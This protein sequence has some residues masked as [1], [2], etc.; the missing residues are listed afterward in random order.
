MWQSGLNTDLYELTMMQ[1]YLLH[2]VNPQVAF[3][4][5]FRRQPYDGGFSVFAGLDDLLDVLDGIRFSPEDIAFL[6]S[7]GIFKKPFLDYLRDFRF[8]GDVYAVDEGTLVFPNEPLVRVHGS[9]IECQLIESLLL[10]VV[11]F[12]TLVATKAARIYA[13]A[14]GRGVLEFG[15]RRA[16]GFD[17]AKSATRAAYIGGCSA[18]SNTLAGK[19]YDIP[20]KGTMAHSWVMAFEDE[21]EAFEKFADMYPDSAVLLIDTYDTLGSGI[22]NAIPVGRRLK[23]EGKGFGV[24]LDSGDLHYLSQEIRRR[25]DE[26]GLTDATIVASNELNEEIIHQLVTDGAP[27]DLWGVGTHLV[28]GGNDASLTGVYKLAAKEVAGDMVPTLKVSNNPEKT[29]NP[30]VKQVHRFFDGEDRPLADL[31]CLEEEELETGGAYT[32]YHPSIEYGHFKMRDYAEIRPLLTKKMESGSRTTEKVPLKQIRERALEGIAKLSHSYT[33]IINP[34][35][36]KVSLSRRLR[37]MKFRMVN[38]YTNNDVN[39]NG[40]HT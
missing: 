30:A 4:M 12:Q 38:E 2:Q 31:I 7:Q 8:R 23:N 36:Y 5:F 24:R 29:T 11:N 9:L 40:A 33:R 22:E 20:V 32:F 27:I 16:Q 15:L 19:L 39:G 1:G 26:A 35:I 25:L 3:D 10:N 14:E 21:R 6:E 28:T 13:A 34:H 37:D 17:G 18:T